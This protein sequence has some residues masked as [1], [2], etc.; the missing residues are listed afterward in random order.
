MSSTNDYKE[1]HQEEE[2][3]LLVRKKVVRKH[4]KKKPQIKLV[5]LKEDT[6]SY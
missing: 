3:V 2:N 5:I 4:G 6:W 1:K